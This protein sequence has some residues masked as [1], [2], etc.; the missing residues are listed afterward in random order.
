MTGEKNKATLVTGDSPLLTG[1]GKLDPVDEHIIMD[2][3]Q[4]D[5][6]L[7]EG[8]AVKIESI[9][10]LRKLVEAAQS[11]HKSFENQVADMTEK[12]AAE[13][14]RVRIEEGYSWRAVARHFHDLGDFGKFHPPSNQ[15]AGMAL[16]ERAAKNYDEDYMRS[17]WNGDVSEGGKT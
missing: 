9:E 15:L 11:V 17:P 16:C 13:V 5:V 8:G 10:D 2:A 6:A 12:E 4:A 1:K 3:E 7:A 14:R